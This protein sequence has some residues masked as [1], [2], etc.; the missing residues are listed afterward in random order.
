MNEAL[1]T[2]YLGEVGSGIASVVVVTGAA[3]VVVVAEVIGTIV[4]VDTMPA[5]WPDEACAFN[6]I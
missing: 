6:T 1:L 3:V 5:D 4:G 2:A